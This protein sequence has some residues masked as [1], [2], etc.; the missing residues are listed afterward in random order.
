MNI[1]IFTD[2]ETRDRIPDMTLL[3]TKMALKLGSWHGQ[4]ISIS[5]S[6]LNILD[7]CQYHTIY[8][9]QSFHTEL[10]LTYAFG[11][12]QSGKFFVPN[13]M[14]TEGGFDS[15]GQWKKYS[16]CNLKIDMNLFKI[17]LLYLELNPK[18]IKT[19]VLDFG[20]KENETIAFAINHFNMRKKRA[21]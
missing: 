10:T 4:V 12:Y 1:E 15:C 11:I 19:V 16:N 7:I 13:E 6:K 21:I 2:P 17:V 20:A 14:P 8:F 18:T 3:S 9:S 5:T